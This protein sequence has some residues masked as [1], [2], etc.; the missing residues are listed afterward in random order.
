MTWLRRHLQSTLVDRQLAGKG[1]GGG[2][3][4]EKKF[5]IP[6][7]GEVGSPLPREKH[8][9]I[10]EGE[11]EALMEDRGRPEGGQPPLSREKSQSH[12]EKIR[13]TEKSTSILLA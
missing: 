1:G 10:V 5:S 2:V 13:K 11:E 9:T 3:S 8:Q 4:G 12:S 7:K 6:G